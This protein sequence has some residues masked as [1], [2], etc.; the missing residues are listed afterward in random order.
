[1]IYSVGLWLTLASK[2]K[3]FATQ[4]ATTKAYRHGNDHR[5]HLY[6]AVDQLRSGEFSYLPSIVIVEDLSDGPPE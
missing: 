3:H 4:A 1:M 6:A 2:W 5:Q